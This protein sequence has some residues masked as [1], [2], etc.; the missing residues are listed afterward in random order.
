MKK[1]N[2]IAAKKIDMKNWKEIKIEYFD[3]EFSVKVPKHCDI[4]EMK[5]I[6]P[7]VD[8][9]QKIEEALDYPIA[10]QSLEKIIEDIPKDKNSITV[11]I[12]ISDNTRPVPYNCDNKEGILFPI[13]NRL[14]KSGVKKENIVIIIGCGTHQATSQLWKEDALG[15]KIVDNYRIIDHDC[16]SED[17]HPLG[18]LQGVPVKVNKA[19]WE[20][21]IHIITG[22]VETHLMAGASGGKKS[23]LSG[24]G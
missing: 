22:L 8:P 12:S 20:S 4:L 1:N 24:N 6:S 11:A 3:R 19:F 15:N 18:T 9:Q 16:Y 21:D 23:S 13:L 5:Q 14:K 7:L 2:F 17:L 10:S